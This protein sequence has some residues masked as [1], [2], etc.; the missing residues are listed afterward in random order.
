M[1]KV[2]VVKRRSAAFWKRAI[3]DQRQS[4]VP[5]SEFCEQHGLALSTFQRWRSRLGSPE[6]SGSRAR[7]ADFLPVH[8][9]DRREDGPFLEI[10]FPH[11]VRVRVPEQVSAESLKR[12]LWAVEA[13][14]C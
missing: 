3:E 13:A 6:S 5:Q 1:A 7:K 12:V 11:G 10:V 8:V 4:G 2:R 9:V 14:S